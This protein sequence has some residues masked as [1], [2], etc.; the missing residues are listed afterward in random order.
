VTLLL[1]T[2]SSSSFVPIAL[3]LIER[4]SGVR[5][6]Q[7]APRERH[8][9]VA[10]Y[11]G[12]DPARPCDLWIPAVSAYTA[13]DVP[14]V[15]TP[16][17][18]R[19]AEG[20]GSRFPFDLFAAM[21]FWL[22][23][24][25]NADAEDHA[26]D[27]HER[28]RPECSVQHNR[29]VLE[30]PIV[31]AY[32]LLLESWLRAKL[33]MEPRSGL[34]GGKRCVVVLSHDV[35][36]PLDPSLGFFL[37]ASAKHLRRGRVFRAAKYAAVHGATAL[38]HQARGRPKQRHWLFSEVLDTEG[39]HGFSSTFFFSAVGNFARGAYCHDVLYDVRDPSFQP[40]FKSI[41]R[42]GC[43][44]GLHLSY[45]ARR[46]SEQMSDEIRALEAASGAAVLG[47]RH[48]I[49]H[50]K[51]PFWPTLA[52]HARAKLAYDS[53]VAFNDRPGYRLGIAFPCHL[54]NPL[55]Q[56]RIGTMQ[57]P[58]LAMD[59][60]FFYHPNQTVDSV[61]HQVQGLLEQMKRYRGVAAID[62]HV[63]TS[64]PGSDAYRL[65]GETY[66]AILEMLAADAEVAVQSCG[67]VLETFSAPP[68]NRLQTIAENRP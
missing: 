11:H 13:S 67:Q 39:R 23:D 30:T 56:E 1:E 18:F 37:W 19:A 5:M 40:V 44:I 51:R 8:E 34:P 26:F 47:S 59:G 12:H 63:R 48:H 57:I 55:S 53:S 9:H 7:V 65:W 46:G 45:H 61:L 66:L 27:K 22:A 58:C 15:P 16:S 68:A 28:L 36:A 54:W 60:G 35:D 38:F 20:A 31:N 33:G 43:D 32:L 42:A 52:D 29:D 24:E 62:W 25:G 50:M 3:E 4:F 17:D 41:L 64:Y 6:T 2:T 10:V 14:G 49:F 21:R